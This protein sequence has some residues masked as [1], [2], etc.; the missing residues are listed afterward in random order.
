[1]GKLT[2]RF[3]FARFF[4]AGNVCLASLIHEGKCTYLCPPHQTKKCLYILGNRIFKR[5][6]QKCCD[7]VVS[8]NQLFVLGISK[9][10]IFT[11]NLEESKSSPGPGG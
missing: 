5:S 9:G 2:H 11:V 10:I 4:S 1:M 6:S 3:S 8:L 7:I